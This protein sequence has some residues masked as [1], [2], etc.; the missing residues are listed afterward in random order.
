MNLCYNVGVFGGKGAERFGAAHE[1]RKVDDMKYY[2][3][4]VKI[5]NTNEFAVYSFKVRCES[6]AMFLAS[7]KDGVEHV[8][9][10]KEVDIARRIEQGAMVGWSCSDGLD[11]VGFEECFVGRVW[12]N[13]CYCY[14][15]ENNVLVRC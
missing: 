10:C 11:M 7:K 2:F 8:F 5:R 14:Y 15:D 6:R 4:G 1:G 3:V 13:G 12:K 9:S